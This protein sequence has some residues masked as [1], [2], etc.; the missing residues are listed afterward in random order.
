MLMA[1]LLERLELLVEFYF[2][3]LQDNLERM[4][5]TN[6]PCNEILTSRVGQLVSYDE[7][8]GISMGFA[9]ENAA[10]KR[11]IISERASLIRGWPAELRETIGRWTYG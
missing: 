5:E 3:K 10:L 11:R 2:P 6:L 7:V 8:R 4:F 9:E 1:D